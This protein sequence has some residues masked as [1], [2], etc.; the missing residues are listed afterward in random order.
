MRLRQLI[1]LPLSS[2]WF[3]TGLAAAI[4]SCGEDGASTPATT[5]T[6]PSQMV[7]APVT[8][9]PTTTTTTPAPPAT[10]PGVTP[11]VTPPSNPPVNPTV[12]GVTPPVT[13]PTTT[14][15]DTMPTTSGTS[16]D[17]APTDTSS[18]TDSTPPAAVEWTKSG[19]TWSVT[20]GD[21]VFEVDASTGARITGFSLGGTQVIV[22]ESA[23]SGSS[24]GNENNFGSTFTLSPQA[25]SGW[26]PPEHMDTDTYAAAAE[27]A[28]LT[29]ES[30]SGDVNGSDIQVTKVFTADAANNTITI[31][32]RVT[33]GGSGSASWAPW[34]ITR[35]PRN[36]ITFFGTGSAVSGV[37]AELTIEEAGAYSFWSYSAADV[38]E[39]EWGDKWVGDGKGWLA[40]AHEG[41]LLLMQFDDIEPAQFADGEGEIEIYASAQDPYVEI[42]PQGAYAPIAGGST[43]SWSVKWSLHAIPDTVAEEPGQALG[44]LA[45]GLATELGAP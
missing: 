21:A 9:V 23:V 28:V 43:L 40:H 26:P 30:D 27:G 35:V 2:V 15:T 37:P 8:P 34:Q 10:T 1:A 42:E 45:S 36:G 25:D 32:Y 3:L 41:V 14:T 16:T 7:P 22:P 12:P 44:D 5:T 33:N 4:T 39:H 24:A 6:T 13:P 38:D 31:E 20:L 18:G 19:N 17:T 11:P 29:M